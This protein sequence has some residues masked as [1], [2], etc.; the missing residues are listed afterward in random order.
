MPTPGA[1]HIAAPSTPAEAETAAAASS[2]REC[3]FSGS[4]QRPQQQQLAASHQS[5][6]YNIENEIKIK[7]CPKIKLG[8]YKMI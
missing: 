7:I 1:V 6:V 8:G 3:F 2:S 4:G 5:Q